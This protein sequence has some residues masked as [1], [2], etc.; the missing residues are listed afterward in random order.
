M[1]TEP[2]PSVRKGRYTWAPNRGPSTGM[3]HRRVTETP[4]WVRIHVPSRS[5]VDVFSCL[6]TDQKNPRGKE[7]ERQWG[8]CWVG[9]KKEQE[10][11]ER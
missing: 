3:L 11:T 7:T 10:H 5:R 6:E 2:Y 1:R 9:G 8:A 4:G